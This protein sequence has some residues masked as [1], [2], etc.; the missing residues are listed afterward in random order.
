MYT[1]STRRASSRDPRGDPAATLQST[2]EEPGG[3]PYRKARTH[4]TGR[5]L[6]YSTK[7]YTVV[8]LCYVTQ[9]YAT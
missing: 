1:Q 4:A 6:T 8:G 9:V 7:R 5:T 2:Q 3:R